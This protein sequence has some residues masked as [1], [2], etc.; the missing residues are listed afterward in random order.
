MISYLLHYPHHNPCKL[1]QLN[2]IGHLS[3]SSFFQA[4]L[5]QFGLE[6]IYQF[7]KRVKCLCSHSQYGLQRD[8]GVQKEVMLSIYTFLLSLQQN[9]YRHVEAFPKRDDIQKQKHRR[10]H[11]HTKQ[12]HT[13]TQ[14]REPLWPTNGS[15]TNSACKDHLIESVL[16]ATLLL[17]SLPIEIWVIDHRP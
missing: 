5:W 9:M 4:R 2:T 16:G 15:N 12:T 1:P 8:C 11:K 10:N 6:I 14:K 7:K 17:F 13:R 3:I